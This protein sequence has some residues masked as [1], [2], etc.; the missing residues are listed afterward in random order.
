[1]ASSSQI[2]PRE[3]VVFDCNI[4]LQFLLNPHGPAG[5]CM[6]IALDGHVELLISEPILIEL[7]ELPLKSVATK[8]GID[9]AIIE[10]LIYSLL[11]QATYVTTVTEHFIHPIDPDDS[12]Y[13]NLALSGNAPVIVSRDRHL[14]GLN[15]PS[16]PWSAGFRSQFPHLRVIS[17][18][19]FLREWDESNAS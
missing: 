2:S 3:R 5:R 7:R 4:F 11:Q 10:Q 19:Q 14:L 1:M 17:A 9:E 12:A 8:N 13:V 16:K 15:D 18:E 6:R